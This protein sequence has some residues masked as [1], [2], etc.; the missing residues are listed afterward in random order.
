MLVLSATPVGWIAALVIAAG[1]VAYSYLAAKMAKQYYT[2]NGNNVDFVH[3]LSID[4][5]CK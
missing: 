2:L 3:H 5:V 4:A 1:G